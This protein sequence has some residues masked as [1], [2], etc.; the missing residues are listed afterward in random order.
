MPERANISSIEALDAFKA[1]LIVYLSKARPSLEEVSDEVIRTRIWLQSDQVIY[2]EN[3]VRR[4]IKVLEQAQQALFSA[5]L[6]KLRPATD[7]EQMAVHR[8]KRALTEAEE[9]LKRV[10]QWNREFD[11]R[12]EPM[13]KQLDQLRT[14]LTTDM[15]KAVAHLD[16]VVKTLVAYTDMTA[17]SIA[18]AE[19]QTEPP[20]AAT[21]AAPETAPSPAGSA[22]ANPGGNL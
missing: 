11:S 6:A 21:G 8:A 5:G 10:K 19:I 14:V 13:A 9:K 12:I 7:A 17:P 16:R 20:K 1:N 18:D 22:S 2:W 15:P 4:R 3:Q